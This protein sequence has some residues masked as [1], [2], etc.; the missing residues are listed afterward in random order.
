MRSWSLHGYRHTHS[1]THTHTPVVLPGVHLS[2][3]DPE[4]LGKQHE[5]IHWPF[6]LDGRGIGGRDLGL[7]DLGWPALVR[8]GG[9]PRR[10]GALRVWTR[11]D[12]APAGLG[13][14][15]LSG[16]HA[17][18]VHSGGVQGR[19]VVTRKGT[20]AHGHSHWDGQPTT[21]NCI[22]RNCWEFWGFVWVDGRNP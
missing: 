4:L 10:P 22:V 8:A 17:Q 18:H 5:G 16:H 3:L 6:A 21:G 11:G 9:G 7:L 20:W 19:E 14:A 12:S 1:L 13:G 2:V 15:A